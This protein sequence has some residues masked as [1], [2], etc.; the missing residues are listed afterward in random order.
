MMRC[1]Y[2]G[3]S[4]DHAC[5]IPGEGQCAWVCES[6]AVCSA[7]ACAPRFGMWLNFF[8][9]LDEL[10]AVLCRSNRPAV[11]EAIR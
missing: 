8:N 5:L 7:P 11:I 4:D 6:P 1:V 2:C 10:S 9:W 3:C